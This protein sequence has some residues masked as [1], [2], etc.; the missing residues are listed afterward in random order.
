MTICSDCG[1]QFEQPSRG[2]PRIR[3]FGCSPSQ[4]GKFT[5]LP[6]LA[7]CAKPGC[8]VVFQGIVGRL[9]CS[10]TCRVEEQ[11]QRQYASLAEAKKAT[12]CGWCG[13]PL[14]Y[15]THRKRFCGDVCLTQHKRAT[16]AADVGSNH[17]RRCRRYGVTYQTI[18]RLAIFERDKWTCWICQCHS[19][20]S[21]LR[22]NHPQRPTLDHVIPLSK[23]GSHTE[24]NVRLACFACNMKKGSKLIQRIAA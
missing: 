11:N 6:T 5:T 4:V 1:D 18:D 2:R 17:R 7:I 24:G 20:A 12:P 13:T 16:R 14:P 15:G 23:G 21:L 9:Y 22:T 19:P 10:A 3:C 8:N